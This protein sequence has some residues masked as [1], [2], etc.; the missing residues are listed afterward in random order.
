MENLLFLFCCSDPTTPGY[1]SYE[2]STR[3]NGTNIP[4]IP[5]LPISWANAQVLLNELK[6]GGQNRTISLVNNG[7]ENSYSSSRAPELIRGF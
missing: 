5:S 1:P 3:T 4:S 2:N 6:E 7:E